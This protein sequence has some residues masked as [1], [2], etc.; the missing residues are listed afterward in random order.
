MIYYIPAVLVGLV[1]FIL[2]TFWGAKLPSPMPD[3]LAPDKISHFLAYFTLTWLALW[4]MIRNGQYQEKKAWWL[5]GGI[6]LYGISL[7]IVQF[8]F[9][10]G[11]YFEWWDM[12]A[13]LVGVLIAKGIIFFNKSRHNG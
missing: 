12:L 7:E 13:N 4:A 2:S 8:S 11:R 3:T 5:V 9:F 1:I 6:A 10:P